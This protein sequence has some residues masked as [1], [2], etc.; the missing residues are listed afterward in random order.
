MWHFTI[1]ENYSFELLW[2]QQ[3]RLNNLNNS[4][5]FLYPNIIFSDQVISICFDEFRDVHLFL[6]IYGLIVKIIKLIISDVQHNINSQNE[7]NAE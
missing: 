2:T 7:K 3:I 5:F 6:I 1:F 4:S